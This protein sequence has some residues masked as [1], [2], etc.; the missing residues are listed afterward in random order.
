[1][2]SEKGAVGGGSQK[3]LSRLVGIKGVLR[4][5]AN[6]EVVDGRDLVE[7]CELSK[8]IGIEGGVVVPLSRGQRRVWGQGTEESQASGAS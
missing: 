3:K 5:F 8:E 6:V 7:W 2:L 1:M 4:R